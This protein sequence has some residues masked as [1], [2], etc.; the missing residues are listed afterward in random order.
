MKPD[1]TILALAIAVLSLPIAAM[2]QSEN[3]SAGTTAGDE[4]VEDIVVVGEKSLSKLRR[5]VYQAEED[6]YSIYNKLND[7]RDYDV[8]C[9]Y[10]KPTGSNIKNHVCRARFVTNAYERH[11]RR[12]R[13]NMSRVAN[14]ST[15]AKLEEQT[16]RYQEN[17]E[18]LIAQNPELE[19]ALIRY[20]T[21]RAQFVATREQNHAN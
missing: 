16:A 1:S 7:N 21:L 17:L 13:N 6:F 8:R 12:N 2:A 15:D 19:Q 20:N 5:E 11:A 10:E 3:S 4:A 18:T 9:Y 14:Q